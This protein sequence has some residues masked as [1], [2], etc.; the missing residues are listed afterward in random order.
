MDTES[1]MTQLHQKIG[2]LETRLLETKNATD[3]EI[4]RYLAASSAT[5]TVDSPVCFVFKEKIIIVVC[6]FRICGFRDEEA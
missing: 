1:K 5:K 2:V 6:S 3:H 4:D